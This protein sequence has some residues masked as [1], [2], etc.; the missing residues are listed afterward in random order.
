MACLLFM[1]LPWL[2]GLSG[3]CYTFCHSFLASCGVDE[4]LGFHS[5]YLASFLGW[6][7][8][9]HGPFL[10]QSNPYPFCRLVSTHTM[11]PHC[12]YHAIVWF[13]LVRP[14][15]AYCTFSFCSVPVAQYYRWACTHAILGFL[16]P[17]HCFGASLAH[18]IALGASLAHFILLGILR[19]FH[20]LGHPRAHSN[21]SFP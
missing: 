5:L 13:V 21:P 18:S 17:F 16:G 7:L 2:R 8:L 1:C 10:L 19:P 14:L 11:S 6:V 12:F 20:F 3:L 9:G 4:S 15:W